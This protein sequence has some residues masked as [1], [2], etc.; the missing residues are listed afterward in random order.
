MIKLNI[1]SNITKYENEK[2]KLDH[3]TD[4]DTGNKR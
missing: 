4:S 2:K 3:V 1:N